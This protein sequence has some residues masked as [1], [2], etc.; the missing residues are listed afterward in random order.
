MTSNGFTLST[1]QCLAIFQSLPEGTKFYQ[2]STAQ[3]S[4]AQYTGK[5]DKVIAAFA[6]SRQSA[7]VSSWRSGQQ[8]RTLFGVS[9]VMEQSFREVDEDNKDYCV[10]LEWNYE[11]QE[12]DLPEL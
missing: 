11:D 3:G 5:R 4:E 12:P 10:L 8:T 7:D 6:D 1:A 2:Y 9:M